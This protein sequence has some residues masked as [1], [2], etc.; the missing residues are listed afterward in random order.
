MA[1]EQEQ[2]QQ[3]QYHEE[4]YEGDGMDTHDGGDAHEEN[5]DVRG[6]VLLAS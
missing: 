6:H 1:E 2:M 3:E 5:A 4:E